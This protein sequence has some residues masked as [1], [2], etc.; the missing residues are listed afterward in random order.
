MPLLRRAPP[1][2]TSG[3]EFIL[4]K[5]RWKITDV[6][7]S[8]TDTCFYVDYIP[9]KSTRNSEK[10]T[11]YSNIVEVFRWLGDK[12]IDQLGFRENF[13]YWLNIE[14]LRNEDFV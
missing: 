14:K 4:D 13:E 1:R 2:H 5:I 11:Q 8:K 6:Y 3:Q 12:K 7:Y 10:M 9:V